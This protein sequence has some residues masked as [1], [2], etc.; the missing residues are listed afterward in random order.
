MKDKIIPVVSVLVGVLAF[1]LTIRYIQSERAKLNELKQAIYAEARKI[2][3]AAARH[4]IPSG[5]TIRPADLIPIEVFERSAPDRV[6]LKSEGRLLLGKKTQFEIKKGK[7]ILWS[8]IEGGMRPG[9]GLAPIIKHR[10]RAI[11]LSISGAAAVSGMVQPNDRVDVLG[12]FSFPSQSVPGQMETVTL[13]VLQDV[14]VLATGQTLANQL[15]VDRGPRRQAGYS[16]V[17]LEVTPREAELLV[18]AQQTQGRLTLSLRNPSD[19]Y[20]EEDLPSVNFEQLQESLPELNR[21]RQQSIRHNPPPG[22]TK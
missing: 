13:T 20:Y 9:Q 17:S 5:T 2:E 4:D 3:V 6:V 22:R 15:T 16:T 12:T 11:S 1:F 8:D 7:P 18:F 21:Y 14:T 10:M 19:V